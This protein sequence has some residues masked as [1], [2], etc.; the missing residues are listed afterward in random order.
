MCA[1]CLRQHAP[2]QSRCQRCAT[3]L[4]GRFYDSPHNNPDGGS[5]HNL[6]GACLLR[7]P[8]LAWCYAAVPYAPPWAG[9]I[10]RYK[11]AAQPGLALVLA[12]LMQQRCPQGVAALKGCDWV[13]PLP[14][15]KRRLAERGFNQA[16]LLAQALAPDK[17]QI[18]HLLRVRETPSQTRLAPAQR[19]RNVRGAFVLAPEFLPALRGARIGLVDDVMTSGA[20]L[21]EAAQL[22]LKAGAAEVGA[23]VFARTASV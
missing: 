22:L 7:P 3:P 9:L 15:A 1:D 2:A 6:C 18:Q 23:L 19:Q 10:A 11:F 17:T 20:S 4:A 5:H 12:D 8:P 13:L 16:Q 14:L 21:H